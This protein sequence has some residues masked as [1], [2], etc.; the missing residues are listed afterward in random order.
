[1]HAEGLPASG[2]L[3]PLS[4]RRHDE[5][6]R[7]IIRTILSVNE[8]EQSLIL[9]SSVPT[10]YLA[11]L[12]SANLNQLVHGANVAA[13][14]AHTT[15]LETSNE[16]ISGPVLSIAVSCIGR[17][18]LLGDNSE[19]EAQSIM[20]SL[21]PSA[22]QIG[23]YAYGQLAPYAVGACDLHNQTMTLTTIYEKD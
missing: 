16:K 2:L 14:I 10:G 9:A 1:V 7:Q 3:F 23:Y 20:S 19:R 15:L 21:P 13:Q 18:L 6:T 8:E 12:A 17:R 5:D 22:R 11:K 4:I